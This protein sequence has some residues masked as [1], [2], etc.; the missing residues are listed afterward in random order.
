MLND[1]QPRPDC[2]PIVE[3]RRQAD[4]DIEVTPR[5]GNG[6]CRLPDVSA[7][8]QELGLG[9]YAK[10]FED[11]EIDFDSLPYL[12]EKMLEQIGLPLGPRARLLAAISELASG[13]ARETKPAEAAKARATAVPTAERR[14]ITVMFC[15]LVD[16]TK[17]AARLDPEDFGSVMK[18]FQSACAVVIERYAG[19]VSQYRG[20]G[21]EVYFG[22]PAAHEDAAERAVRAGLEVIEAVKAIP[23][24]EPLSVRVGIST[25]MVMVSDTGALGDPAIPSGAVGGTLHVAA[26]LQALATPNSVIISESTSRLISAR[27]DQ[28]ALGA[29]DL[30]GVAEPVRAFRVRRVR[31]DSSRFEVA[32]VKAMTPLVD[33]RAELA[34]LQQRWREASE[35]EG[36]AVFV[37]GV[38]GIGKSRLVHELEQSLAGESH[39]TLHF[40]CLPHCMQSALF[41]VI[42]QIER[43]GELAADDS[44]EI[45]LKKIERLLLRATKRVDKVLF[46]IAQMLSVPVETRPPLLSLTAQQLKMQTLFVLVE[47]LLDLSANKPVFCLLEDAQWIDPSTQELL[48]LAARRIEKAPILLVVTHRPEY[49]L[50][51]GMQANVSGVTITRLGRRD[52]TEMAVLALR[53]QTVPAAVMKRIIDDCD[54]IPLFIEELARGAVQSGGFHEREVN[55]SS[56]EPAPSLVPDSLRDSLVARLDRA[57]QA[58]TVAQMAAVIGREFGYDMLLHVSSLASSELDSTLEHLTQSEIVQLIDNRPTPRYAFKHAL[59]RD[60]AYESLLRSNRRDIHARVAAT[61]EKEWPDIV[62]GQPELLA[63][64]YSLA[65]KAE[66]AVRYWLMGGR[67]AR[68]RSANLEAIAQF[69]KAL[70][71]LHFLP[72]TPQRAATE[73]DIQLSLGLCFIAV[74]GYSADDTRKAFE[75]ACI[76]SAQL[77]DPQKEIQSIFGLWGHHWMRARHDRA[78]ELGETLLA[79]AEQFDDPITLIVGH[80]SL[81]STLFTLGNFV[82][83]REHL[84]RAVALGQRAAHDQSSLSLSYAVDPRIAAQLMLA[85]DLW[86]LGYPDQARGSVL[87]AL[88]HASERADPYTLAF[89]H[90]VTSAVHLLRGEF[91]ESLG[92]A[93]RSL[94]L[95]RE[96][97]FNLYALYSRFGRGCALAKLGQEQHAIVEIQEGIEE[98][99]RSNL[100]YMRGFMLG[101]LA[102]V[103]LQI[104]D[105]EAALSTVDEALQQINDIAGRAWEAELRRLRGDILRVA[106]PDAP[107]AAECSYNDAIEVARRQQA[108]S[109]ELRAA[110]SLAR[111]LHQLGRTDEAR[112]RL[113]GVLGWFAEGAGT[114]DLQEAKL[115]L[116]DLSKSLPHEL[117]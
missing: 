9:R 59:M 107:E 103:Q 4:K 32:H 68:S 80:R 55:D 97:R 17:L 79:K 25:G 109:L 51:G 14:Q 21:I 50:R 67:R 65:G 11:N 98:A 69:Q 106:R 26:R 31:E 85:W 58:R 88:Q 110:V 18:A 64:H 93:D 76:L 61:L 60:V 6:D 73:L 112:A 30:K 41:P 7:W 75:R 47:L 81:G 22:W 20:D 104:V 3:A 78:I 83:A 33:R 82:Q 1:D 27:F 56:V 108:R 77:A 66:F 113:S 46:L 34:F 54:S 38:P 16:S 105:A 89:A 62:A 74:Q 8:L 42:Q 114:A 45:K 2:R 12:T 44:D 102:S 49:Q 43:L 63:Y 48:E 5:S 72:E 70:E 101:W 92:H 84:L 86:I 91:Q 39:F 111:L 19:H 117:G 99:R 94:A 57:P 24:P 87:E 95:S 29:Q 37:S 15:D 35:G 115:L 90:Y 71:C 53:E 10:A 36:Q 116:D 52:V 23:G 13:P 40:Q 28:E 96:H 100:G